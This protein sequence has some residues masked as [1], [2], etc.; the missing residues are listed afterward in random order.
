M[1]NVMSLELRNCQPL[2]LFAS[3]CTLDTFELNSF[4]ARPLLSLLQQRE[5][6]TC[7]STSSDGL[8]QWSSALAEMDRV[9]H[10]G[11]RLRN[12]TVQNKAKNFKKYTG[13]RE[14]IPIPGKASINTS[15]SRYRK[16]VYKFNVFIQSV[17]TANYQDCSRSM[18]VEE[19]EDFIKFRHPV[20]EIELIAAFCYELQTS[21]KSVHN[22]YQLPLMYRKRRITS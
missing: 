21:G 13:W 16:F 3:K 5:E 17:E 2:I 14:A 9:V 15:I 22:E 20:G 19:L 4:Y 7:V 8:K 12:I 6:A 1:R 10:G 18:S 11:N